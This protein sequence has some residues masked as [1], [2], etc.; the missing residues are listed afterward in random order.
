VDND[1]VMM[2][3]WYLVWFDLRLTG[4]RWGQKVRVWGIW[5]ALAINHFA[6]TFFWTQ[7]KLFVL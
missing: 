3:I 4:E 6:T 1:E 5:H 7:C 2:R